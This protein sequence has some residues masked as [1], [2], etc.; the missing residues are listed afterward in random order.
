MIEKRNRVRQAAMDVQTSKKLTV[1]GE[2]RTTSSMSHGS[3]G[4]SRVTHIAVGELDRS[5]D[6]WNEYVSEQTFR[7]SMGE[8]RTQAYTSFHIEEGSGVVVE[9]VIFDSQVHAEEVDSN[10]RKNNL[11]ELDASGRRKLGR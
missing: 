5:P 2:H 11:W 9:V 10:L 8:V 4:L 3:C 6:T 1:I 7:G